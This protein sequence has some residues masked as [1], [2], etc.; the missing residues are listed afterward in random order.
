MIAAAVCLY[1]NVRKSTPFANLL[2][3]TYF[4][5]RYGNHGYEMINVTYIGDTLVAHKVTGA[6]NVP[7]GEPTFQVD[8]NPRVE[9]PSKMLKP[10]ELKDDVAATQWGTK[11]LS[12]FAGV[13]HVSGEGFVNSQWLEGQ[14]ILV[15]E[16]FSFAWLP[17]GHQVFFG[18]PSPELTLKMLR[19]NDQGESGSDNAR[20]FLERCL[21]ETH[22]MEDEVE[23]SQ[24]LSFSTEQ[25]GYFNQEG[26][27]E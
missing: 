16:Y 14:L 7:K 18:R 2:T 19:A 25:D 11:H 17:L 26:C 24:G 6:K 4:P 27:F 20:H 10:I 15:G 1:V 23:V 13:G 3:F 21:E 9:H 5:I 22:H 8:L 12:R